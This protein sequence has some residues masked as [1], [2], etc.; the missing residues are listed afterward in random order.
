MPSSKQWQIENLVDLKNIK[1]SDGKPVAGGLAGVVNTFL[2]VSLNKRQQLSNWEKRPLTEEQII[3][4]ACDACCLLDVYYVLCQR[5]HPFVKEL[6]R[7]SYLNNTQ[8]HFS[9]SSLTIANNTSPFNEAAH[10]QPP[11]LSS[12]SPSPSFLSSSSSPPHR[13]SPF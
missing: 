2:N 13:A 7:S 6:P 10:S 4:G 12:F 1:T 5:N 9:P 3:Y 11:P 8:E